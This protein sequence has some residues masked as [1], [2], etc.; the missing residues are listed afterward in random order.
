[1][2]N[3]IRRWWNR[4]RIICPDFFRFAPFSDPLTFSFRII[5]ASRFCLSDVLRRRKS[6]FHFSSTFF[7]PNLIFCSLLC[8]CCSLWHFYWDIRTQQGCCC[9][10]CWRSS[11][12][13]TTF[14]SFSF[15]SPI[16]TFFFYRSWILDPPGE[17]KAVPVYLA[18]RCFI[19]LN[20][21]QN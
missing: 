1:M 12:N 16:L 2:S 14:V 15:L 17:T 19:F 21:N 13:N 3:K 9:C 6:S 10:C 18:A 5:S 8:F 11:Q 4:N 7:H 20:L